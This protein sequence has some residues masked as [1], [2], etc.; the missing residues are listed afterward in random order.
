MFLSTYFGALLAVGWIKEAKQILAYAP[1][2]RSIPSKSRI[3][4]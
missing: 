4:A 3:S 2:C 1:A